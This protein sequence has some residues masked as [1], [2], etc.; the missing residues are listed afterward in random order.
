MRL[1]VVVIVVM[2]V[3][4]W[5]LTQLDSSSTLHELKLFPQE[6]LTIENV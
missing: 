6:T 5:Q 1:C 3:M 2:C 4:I